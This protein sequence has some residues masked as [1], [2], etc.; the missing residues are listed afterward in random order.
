MLSYPGQGGAWGAVVPRRGGS[1]RTQEREGA[2]GA[3]VP[4]EG[5]AWGAVVPRRGLGCCRTQEREE[6]G[7]EARVHGMHE[8]SQRMIISCCMDSLAGPSSS[9]MYIDSL[10]GPSSSPMYMDGGSV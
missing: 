9:P 10:A 6:P 4:G 5:E 8:V 2:W 3:V 1:C 7:G